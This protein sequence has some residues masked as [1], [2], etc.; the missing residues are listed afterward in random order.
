MKRLF[1]VLVLV[2][3]P[4][5]ADEGMWMPQQIPALADHLRSLGFTGDAQAFADLTG[6]PMGAVVSLG[7]CSASFVSAEGLMVTNHHCVQGSLQFNSTPDRNLMEAGFL[8]RTKEEEL[9]S[10]PGSRVFVTVSVKE[11]TDAIMGNIDPRATDRERHDI[12]DKRVKER[13]AACEKDGLRCTIAPFFEG[14]MWFEIGQMEI[15]DIR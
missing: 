2:A 6:F 9:W 12:V 11:I 10:G 14:L 5:F 15:Q 1:P 8:A 4:A 3:S 13:T 7:G